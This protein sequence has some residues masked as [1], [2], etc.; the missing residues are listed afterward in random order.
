MCICWC[1]TEI[2]Y[3]MYG[4]TIKKINEL[5]VSIQWENLLFNGGLSSSSRRYMSV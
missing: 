5:S 3:R 1:V 2:N 4:G